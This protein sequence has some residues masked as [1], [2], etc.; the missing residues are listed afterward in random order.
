MNKFYWLFRLFSFS[1]ICVTTLR[2][3]IYRKAVIEPSDLILLHKSETSFYNAVNKNLP[4]SIKVNNSVKKIGFLGQLSQSM[5]LNKQFWD[6]PTPENTELY[7]YELSAEGYATNPKLKKLNH[8]LFKGFYHKSWYN[9]IYKD[10]FDYKLIASKINSDE[11][12]F[13]IISIETLGRFTYGE[14]LNLIITDTKIITVNP[15]N[16]PYF[17]PKIYAQGQIQLPPCW[18]IKNKKLIHTSDYIIDDYI[19]L[20]RFFFYD[21]RELK[22]E[23]NLNNDFKNVL[24]IHSR[25]SKVNSHKFLRVVQKLLQD[26][27]NRMFYLMG[28][29]DQNAL[30]TISNFFKKTSVNKQFKYL[31]EYR[32][33]FNE[34]GELENTNWELT[35]QYLKTSALYLN[36]FP[37]GSGSSRMEAFIS[38]LPVIDLEIDYMDPSK[39]HIKEYILAPLIKKHG[40][41]YSED[42]YYELASKT[43]NNENYRKLIVEE[44]YKIAEE[45]FY[46]SYFWEKIET[47]LNEK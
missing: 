11:L 23:R 45:F 29:N 17:H 1:R 32:M 33:N 46:E 30:S 31:G 42:E 26:D 43:I 37:K 14:L 21:R 4:I 27:S 10:T 36:P 2:Y 41:A 22:I 12:D 24:F 9:R 34:N 25:L 44:Q 5:L 19:F 39:K 40:T 38:G 20:D 28:I 8:S 15:G 16:Y 47:L 7:L 35:K 18:T 13:L 3:I 6:Y